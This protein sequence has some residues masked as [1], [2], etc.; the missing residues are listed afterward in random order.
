MKTYYTSTR[1]VKPEPTTT[2]LLKAS[3]YIIGAFILFIVVPFGASFIDYFMNAV[4][5]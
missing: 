3:L 5:N 2:D 1:P 4:F